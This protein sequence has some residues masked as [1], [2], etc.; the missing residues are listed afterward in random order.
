MEI[1]EGNRNFQPIW[2]SEPESLA[3]ALFAIVRPESESLL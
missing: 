2:P 1:E 3:I